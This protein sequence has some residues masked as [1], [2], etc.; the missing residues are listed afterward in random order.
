M[1]KLAVHQTLESIYMCG[2]SY[3][4][5]LSYKKICVLLYSSYC[6][7]Y[8]LFYQLIVL[9][10]IVLYKEFTLQWSYIIYNLI[11][12]SDKFWILHSTHWACQI[13]ILALMNSQ[14]C[15]IFPLFILEKQ[16]Y[17]KIPAS[18]LESLDLKPVESFHYKV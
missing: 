14:K 10:K 13:S 9:F 4:L 17:I 3:D 7:F 1:H 2:V 6:L 8:Y 12:N 5:N 18:D 16:L 11:Y 15:L